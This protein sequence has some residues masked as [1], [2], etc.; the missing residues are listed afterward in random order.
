MWSDMLPYY[1]MT[2]GISGGAT[3]VEIAFLFWDGSR[4]ALHIGAVA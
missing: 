4:S 2:L 3:I 1:G